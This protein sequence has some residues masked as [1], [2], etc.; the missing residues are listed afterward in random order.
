MKNAK[1]EFFH[2]GYSI[3]LVKNFTFLQLCFLCKMDQ[4][5][6]SGN[7]RISWILLTTHTNL[8][9]F[10]VVSPLFHRLYVERPISS[11]ST[12]AHGVLEKF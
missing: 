1:L 5:K 2:R 11:N 7:F 12:V 3:V 6:V 9:K 10:T 4:E 8:C